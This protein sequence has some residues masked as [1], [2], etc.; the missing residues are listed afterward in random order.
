MSRTVTVGL[1]GSTESLTAADWA[2]R[3]ARLRAVPL[4]VVHAGEQQLHA[5]EPFA[6]EA[7]PLAGEDRSARMLHEAESS[8]TYRHPGPRITAE[9]LAGQPATVLSAAAREAEVLVL[10]SRVLG[11]A[12]GR[13][14]GSVALAVVGRAEG[15]VVLVR[16]GAGVADEHRA[17]TGGSACAGTSYRDVVLG[18]HLREHPDGGVL[19]FA[20]DAA[21]GAPPGCGS[22]TAGT[23]H[24]LRGR[25]RRTSRWRRRGA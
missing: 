16:A 11:H 12:A 25:G 17:G 20:F 7:V 15:P 6:A 13:L 23:R 21:G 14:F 4:R 1:D 24:R 8:L 9:Q 10:G 3:E 18:L 5:Y 2:V 19:E 22:C